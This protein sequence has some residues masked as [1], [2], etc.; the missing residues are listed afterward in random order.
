ML[1]VW[2]GHYKGN[3][4]EWFVVW[5]KTKREAFLQIDPIT[6]EP[7]LN[8]FMELTAPGFVDFT[9]KDVNGEY[10]ELRPNSEEIKAGYWMVLGGGEGKTDDIDGHIRRC[11][12]K[13]NR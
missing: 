1:K 11:M 8:S 12:K 9:P 13:G 2:I 6:G 5:A 10:F 3:P 7:D 4:E